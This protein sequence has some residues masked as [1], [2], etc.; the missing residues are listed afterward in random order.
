M[1]S[2]PAPRRSASVGSI[3]LTPQENECVFG[4]LGRKCTVSSSTRLLLHPPSL[5][6]SARACVRVCV[7]S[8]SAAVVQVYGCERGRGW[9]KRC[10][11]VGCLVKDNPQR[12]YYIRVLDMKVSPLLVPVLFLVPSWSCF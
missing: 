3:L 4:Y 6:P 12:S 5:Q 11:G 9:V 10:C 2:H 1:S 8:L 7:Q